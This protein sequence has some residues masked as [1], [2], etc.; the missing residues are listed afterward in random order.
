VVI[1]RTPEED[2]MDGVNVAALI[3]G[4]V[5]DVS[6]SI[7]SWLITEGYAM[8]EMRSTEIGPGFAK[9]E[10]VRDTSADRPR[11]SRRRSGDR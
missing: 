10:K 9:F 7:G 4:R 1:L 3:P 6:P 2:E 11:R 5:T 8:P